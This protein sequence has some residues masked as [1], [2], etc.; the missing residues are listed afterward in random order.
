MTIVSRPN[1]WRLWHIEWLHNDSDGHIRI[2]D[3]HMQ[4]G[5]LTRA[6]VKLFFLPIEKANNEQSEKKP[7]TNLNKI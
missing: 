6:L 1:E 7:K 4:A 3:L 5:M 2:V